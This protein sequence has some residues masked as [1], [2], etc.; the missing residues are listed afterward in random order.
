MQWSQ[1]ISANWTQAM[2]VAVG[3]YVLGCCTS[4]YYLVRARLGK[5]LRA[6][7]SGSLGARNVGRE[8][9]WRG[10]VGTLAGD[11]GKGVLA[12]WAAHHLGTGAN[13]GAI[14]LVAVVAG[15]IW[16]FQLRFQGGKGVATFL[17]ALLVY[18]FR[19]AVAWGLI[20]AVPCAVFRRLT[21]S[22]ML[23]FAMLP[24]TAMWL[25]RNDPVAEAVAQAIAV[26]LGSAMVLF[27]HR[28]NLGQEVSDILEH[29]AIRPK[30]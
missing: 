22:A 14:A 27:A 18:D 15:H 8:L 3:A 11:F 6:L 2:W 30:H 16:P 10:F 7:G 26:S 19:L 5:D 20:F 24:F 28:K 13:L 12:V 21:L 23:A 17:G 25:A 9:G 1:H 29:R 4:G